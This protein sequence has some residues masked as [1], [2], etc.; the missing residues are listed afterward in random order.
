MKIIRDNKL[1][2]ALQYAAAEG[3]VDSLLWKILFQRDLHDVDPSDIIPKFWGGLDYIKV[4]GR[5]IYFVDVGYWIDGV[6][7]DSTFAVRRPLKGKKK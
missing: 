5:S 7:H 3:C 2:R 6:L 1:F 4:T